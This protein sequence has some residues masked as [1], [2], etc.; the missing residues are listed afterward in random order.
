MKIALARANER[1]PKNT[2]HKYLPFCYH[3]PSWWWTPSPWRGCWGRT[4][5]CSAPGYCWFPSPWLRFVSPEGT[6][7]IF[8][9]AVYRLHTA[10]VER[11]MR[12]YTSR[13]AR[14]S[15]RNEL[16]R[17]GDVRWCT[18]RVPTDVRRAPDL[19]YVDVGQWRRRHNFR[20]HWD[21]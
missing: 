4:R 14:L 20:H 16:K 7:S 12:C 17:S 1:L 13:V 2:I 8:C 11:G 5:G 9:T 18:R 6:T 19:R 21:L 10:T 3:W 15:S